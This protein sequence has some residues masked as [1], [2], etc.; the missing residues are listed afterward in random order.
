MY[1]EE[2]QEEK[3]NHEFQSQ[4]MM[5]KK[6][7]EKG[8]HEFQSQCMMKKSRKKYEIMNFKVNV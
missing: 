8:N 6:Q 1:D 2:K 7:K 5:K 4:C 3:G